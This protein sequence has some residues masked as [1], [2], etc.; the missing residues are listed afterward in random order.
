MTKKGFTLI[1]LLVVILIIGILAAVAVP[2]YQKA[3]EK[4][5]L[6]EAL[7]NINTVVANVDLF[8]LENGQDDNYSNYSDHNNWTTDLSGGTWVEDYY[9]TKYFMYGVDDSSC[10][11]AYRCLNTCENSVDYNTVQYE[12]TRE[13]NFEGGSKYCVGYSSFGK[14]MCKSLTAQGWDDRSNYDNANE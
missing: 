6:A 13:Y 9:I 2:Q 3:V 12:L 8:I 7:I 11:T 5:H 4:S 10:I 1:E 14:S